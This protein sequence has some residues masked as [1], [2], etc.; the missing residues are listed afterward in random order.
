MLNHIH[1][2]FSAPDCSGFLRDFKKYTSTTLL[3]N[4]SKTEPMILKLFIDEVGN[5]QVWEKTNLPLLI[6]SENFLRQKMNYIVENPV[7]KMYVKKAEDWYWSSA[8]PQAI[9]PVT[10]LL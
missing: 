1:M 4:I 7:R 9:L 6:E 5:K 10:S 8:N 2:I 3:Q